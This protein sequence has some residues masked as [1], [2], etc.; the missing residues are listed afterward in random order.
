MVGTLRAIQFLFMAP[1]ILAFLFVLTGLGGP[2]SWYR[3]HFL[4]DHY[5]CRP[6]APAF[7][8]FDQGWLR[9][10][11]TTHHR[12]AVVDDWGPIGLRYD[13]LNDP[14]LGWLERHWVSIQL[15]QAA[16]LALLGGFF[17]A[18]YAAH[19]AESLTKTAQG[20][21]SGDL[22]LRAP[23]GV[24]GDEFDRLAE[25]MNAMLERLETL[26]EATRHAGDSIAHDLRSPLSRLETV[27]S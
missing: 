13:D 23:V 21:M 25:Q 24:S 5:Q 8:R 11:V 15:G 22:S 9:D 20:V 4:R 3:T 26:M 16:V 19:R 14:W 1:C 10:W 7:L 27:S 2:L 6:E 12:S 18:R 17:S